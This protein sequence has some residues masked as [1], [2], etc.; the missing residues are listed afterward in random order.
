MSETVAYKPQRRN[1]AILDRAFELV[2]SVPYRVSARWVFYRL[3]QEGFYSK[4]DDYK[5]QL[6]PALS[7]ARHAF[8]KDWRPDTLADDTRA[9]VVRGNGFR[10]EK[11]WLKALAAQVACNLDYWLKQPHYAECW[12][13]ARA[14]TDQ[15]Q[16]YTEHLT[17]RPMGGQPSIPYKWQIAKDLEQAAERYKVPIVVLYFGDLDQAGGIIS[18]TVET[19]VRAWC[20]VDFTLIRAGL[21]V[22]QV[23]QY[24]VP[25]NIEKPGEYQW[26]AL[27][28][29]GARAIITQHVNRLVSHDY[30]SETAKREDA[31]T[32]WARSKLAGIA[33]SWK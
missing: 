29:E 15:F 12:Y 4:K 5:N 1:A 19:D 3:L 10:D 22:E 2:N 11:A 33:E 31:I 7:D 6:L 16:Y 25:E 18:D 23:A 26:E 9:A 28:D 30:F 17:L 24:N 13:E 32:D 20:A 14:M 21:T 8:Y 27:S